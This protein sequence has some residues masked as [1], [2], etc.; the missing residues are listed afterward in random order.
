M[1][2]KNK[3]VRDIPEKRCIMGNRTP[4]KLKGTRDTPNFFFTIENCELLTF[5]KHNL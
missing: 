4:M 3:K 5:S 1:S 2:K